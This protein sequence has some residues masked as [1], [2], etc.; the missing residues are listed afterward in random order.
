M[1]RITNYGKQSSTEEW[2]AEALADMTGHTPHSRVAEI[3]QVKL[4]KVEGPA[5]NESFEQVWITN[6]PAG[7]VEYAKRVIAVLQ[8]KDAERDRRAIANANQTF[9]GFGPTTRL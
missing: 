7:M 6:I 3:E 8:A 1:A 4:T 2:E 9:T 5:D